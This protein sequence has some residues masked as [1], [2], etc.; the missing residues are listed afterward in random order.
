MNGPP[1]S[2]MGSSMVNAIQAAAD[3]AT[4]GI[5]G[6]A[7]GKREEGGKRQYTGTARMLKGREKRVKETV[8]MALTRAF[9]CN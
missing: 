9:G 1:L 2:N 4:A 3:A 6:H 8:Q 5:R 7:A